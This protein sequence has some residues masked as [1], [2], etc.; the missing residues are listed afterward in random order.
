M[1][2]IYPG[3]T[4]PL[5]DEPIDTQGSFFATSAFLEPDHPLWR[6]SDAAMHW[7]CYERWPHRSEFASAHFLSSVES[8]T[9]NPY[10]GVALTSDAVYISL[11]PDPSVNMASVGLR[12]SGT[13]LQEPLDQWAR[14]VAAS[15]AE[16]LDE[17]TR[18]ALLEVLPTLRRLLPDRDALVSAVDWEATRRRFD[19]W[20]EQA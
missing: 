20:K 8:A 18:G 1:A 13:T 10:W 4:C 14:W 17:L 15:P 7:E 11:N 5:C 6:F 9:R 12:A 2:L 3:A 16:D 19:E